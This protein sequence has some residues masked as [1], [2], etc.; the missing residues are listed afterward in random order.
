MAWVPG[1]EHDVFISYARVDDLTADPDPHQGWVSQFHRHLEIALSKKAGRLDAIKIWRDT[2]QIRGNQ[3]FDQTIEDSIHNSAILVMLASHGYLAS[4][5]CRQELD[6]FYRKAQTD[7]AGLAAGDEYRI[8]H[9]LLNNL[10]RSSWPREVG[11][12]SGFPFHDA[13]DEDSDGEPVEPAGDRFRGCL[14]GLADAI[15]K[16]LTRLKERSAEETPSK[17]KDRFSIYVADIADTLAPV[18]R[19]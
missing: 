9:V 10:P 19:R 8:F 12:T 15:F 1:F 14:R 6:C 13:A 18:R 2:R 3:L 17:T 16:T 5:Y 7:S 4:D 11:R